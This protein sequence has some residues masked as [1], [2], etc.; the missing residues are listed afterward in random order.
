MAFTVQNDTGTQAGANSYNTVQELKDYWTDRNVDYTTVSDA[1]LESRLIAA[2]S[3][4][5]RRY[6]Y[7]GYKSNGRDQTT[8]FPREYLYDYSGECE[9]LVAGV[10]REAKEAVNEYAH[11]LASQDSLQPNGSTDG[12]VKRK[13]EKVGVIEEETEYSPPTAAGNRIS[14]PDADSKIPQDFIVNVAGLAVHT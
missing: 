9:V 13:K 5:D 2:T 11:I 7:A 3:Y 1:I 4:V 10:P 12:T 14:Y 8:E 6:I